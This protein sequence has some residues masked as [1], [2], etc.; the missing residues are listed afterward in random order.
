M[1]GRRRF[2][3]SL[4]ESQTGF[5]QMALAMPAL[6]GGV[7][8]RRAPEAPR[9][10][11]RARARRSRIGVH[12]R[13]IERLSQPGATF[14]FI[15]TLF[16]ATGVYGAIK[17]GEYDAMVAADGEP[18]DILAKALGFNIKAVTIAGQSEMT[19][20]EILSV[21]GIGPRNSLPFL[22][23][24]E[25]RERLQKVPLIKEVSV[26]KLYPN[27]LLIE[28]EERQASALWQKDGVVKVV[29][30]DGM[31]I[32]AMRDRRFVKL[33]LI[34]GDGVNMRLGEYLALLEAAGDLREEI[35]AGVFVSG[36]RWNL[37][38]TDGVD[39]LLPEI[40]PQQAIATLVR[41]QRESH[42]LD[43]AV[44]SIDLREPDRLV[45]RMTDEAA[46]ERAEHDPHKPKPKGG[47]I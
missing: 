18:A 23:V 41:L 39:I 27:R 24:A 4:K 34:V 35:R 15:A 26:T 29:A 11:A 32:D 6:A 28:V 44:L 36:R 16:L 25:V 19:E 10:K 45:A 7:L 13:I 30:A 1:D 22:D 21:S 37:K 42:I 12:H 20:A 9:L 5:A 40:N 38:T 2:L 31:T 47:Q 46:A 33:P 43:K 14:C 8:S 17:G 3:R